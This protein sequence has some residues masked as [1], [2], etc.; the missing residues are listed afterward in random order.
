MKKQVLAFGAV[1]ALVSSLIIFTAHVRA[2][3]AVAGEAVTV[4]STIEDFSLSDADGKQHSLASLKGAKGTALIFVSV[5][6]PVSN[7][8]NA[9]MAKLASDYKAQG[10]NVIGINSN[11]AEVA[12]AIKEHAATNNL[13]FTILKDE[14]NK[15]ADR[16]GANVTPEVFL[17]DASNKLVYHGRIDDA[18]REANIKANDL[19]EA[20]DAVIK[21]APIKTTQA[22]AFGCTIKRV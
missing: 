8:Y 4:G 16:L 19:R 15:I 2:A 20:M 22:R 9:R 3:H 5:Q 18:Q 12:S 13:A 14:K 1:L 21:G 17:L 10:I 11:K 6:C 7:A